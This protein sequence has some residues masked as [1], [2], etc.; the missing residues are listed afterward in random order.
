ML[1]IKVLPLSDVDMF[2]VEGGPLRLI[3]LLHK[4][5]SLRT[6]QLVKIKWS[7]FDFVRDFC[8]FKVSA[9]DQEDSLLALPHLET[10]QFRQVIFP[11][12]DDDFEVLMSIPNICTPDSNS[13]RLKTDTLVY[14]ACVNLNAR[15]AMLLKEII[16]AAKDNFVE[17]FAEQLSV[18]DSRLYV[19]DII[20]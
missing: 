20:R 18:C 15:I 16:G 3:P 6:L 7:I 9:N 19:I 2:T 17:Q 10:L 13:V 1:S 14:D 4:M 5:T 8:G 11:A 12:A